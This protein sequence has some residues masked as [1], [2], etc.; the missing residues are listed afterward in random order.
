M[1]K[2]L[3][4]WQAAAVWTFANEIVVVVMAL[5]QRADH[6]RRFD[7]MYR[8]AAMNHKA[9]QLFV[10]YGDPAVTS[11]VIEEMEFDWITRD[12]GT[13]EEFKMRMKKDG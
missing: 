6:Q 4:F 7:G 9:V 10:E 13:L 8:T 11:R 1:N 12:F 3:L 2:K 5:K